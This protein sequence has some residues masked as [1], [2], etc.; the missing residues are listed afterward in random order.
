[1]VALGVVASDL[2]RAGVISRLYTITTVDPTII[3][4]AD[5]GYRVGSRWINDITQ[6]EFL[7]F[8]STSGAA[9]WLQV[10]S[11][12]GGGATD[13]A[14]VSYTNVG[15][16]AILTVKGALDQLL[17]FPMQVSLSGGSV[18]EVGQSLASV[19]LS[20][21]YNK[22][23]LGQTLVGPS[24]PSIILTDRAA[25]VPGPITADS[26]WTVQGT[27]L[28]GS[29][30][31]SASVSALFWPRRFWGVSAASPSAGLLTSLSS[32]LSTSRAQSRTFTASAE[33]IYFAW[34]SSFGTPSFVVGGFA[35]TAWNKT[36]VS[37]TNAYG[38][39]RNY[40]IWQSNYVNTG[41]GIAVDVS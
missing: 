3:D 37:V 33:Y 8:D 14:H 4:D 26:T 22:S 29:E 31:P 11:G 34:P 21:S 5:D 38:D 15:Y 9:V 36:T 10:G 27:S 12:G 1:M 17:F 20:W 24:A 25:T 40:D 41:V 13:A 16:P 6:A 23:I 30:H 18:N 19:A 32:Q 28:D 39:T 35:S 7:L 2:T